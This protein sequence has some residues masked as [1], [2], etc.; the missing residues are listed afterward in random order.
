VTV[1]LAL[2]KIYLQFQNQTLN[3]VE[4]CNKFGL[5]K[6][7]AE[8]YPLFSLL[9]GITF[10][11]LSIGPFLN[12]D[13]L[14]EFEAATGVIKWGMPY[15]NTVGNLINQPPLGFYIEAL[16][17]K[18]FGESIKTGTILVTLLGLGS[19]IILYKIGKELYG[20]TTGL[21]AAAL[22]AL[23]PWELILSRSF[24]IDVQ[25]LFL[26]L[27]SL[28]VGLIAFRRYSVKLSLV[29]GVVF[30]AAMLTKYFAA[31][32]LIPLFLF[33][34][35]SRPKKAILVFSQLI[36]FL[37]PVLL[38][39]FLWYQ[40]ILGNS[41][42]TIFAHSDFRDLNYSG[43]VLSYSFVGFFVWNYGLGGFFVS[44]TIFSLVLDFAF[45]GQFS[46]VCYLDLICFASILPILITNMVLGVGLNL[47]APYNNAIKYDYQSLP[48]FSLVAASLLGKSF[49]LLNSTKLAINTHRKLIFSI[50]SIGALLLALTILGEIFSANKLST[51]NFLLFRVT[52]NQSIGY[53][54][55]NYTPTN[56]SRLLMNFQYLGFTILLSGFLWL[57]RHRLHNF[58]KLI[59]GM[60]NF[61]S[62]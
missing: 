48:F 8:N 24:L 19:T 40:V 57:N 53:T 28:Y 30:A 50:V 17:F 34:L 46:K 39:S 60:N 9:A 55:H 4:V 33:C 31:F 6:I 52:M 59:R 44:A 49:S 21:F 51:S 42:I 27:L 35:H 61:K 47:K 36:A 43:V 23:S 22:F 1:R 12:G 7:L 5:R 15:V 3:G 37:L 32:M 16:F 25:C 14:W 45:R 11:S 62:S 26:S 56:E 38:L 2:E 10:V 54:F 13:S 41:I 58:F 20:K 18:T 29:S